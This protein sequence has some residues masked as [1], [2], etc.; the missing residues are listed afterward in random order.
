VGGGGHAEALLSRLTPTGVLFC[1]DADAD[2]I[3]AARVRL[4]PFGDRAQFV[5]ANFRTL[6]AELAARSVLSISGIILDLGLS[7]YQVDEP[8]RG[9]SYR[10]NAPL[11]MRFDQRSGTTAA[12]II[13]SY[14][15]QSLAAVLYEFGEERASRRIARA[16]VARRPIR[17]SGELA[18]AV[19]SVCGGRFATKTL[20]R[21]FQ[22]LRIAVNRELDALQAVLED[23][24]V[25]VAT[26]GRIVVISYHSL[27]DRMVKA[28]FRAAAGAAAEQEL[29]PYPPAG[30]I[31]LL[32]VLTRKPLR[33]G[34]EECRRN[35]RARSARLRIAE[36]L[37]A[38]SG[39]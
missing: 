36:R 12:E 18:Q 27:E 34:A 37:S 23:A 32:R 16:I 31:P 4:R 30:R 3:A 9:F 2:A 39:P 13:N 6:R 19:G 17:T 21:V 24:T 25:L 38:E 22:A 10:S 1:F 5:H 35:P 33:P 8:S 15:A 28:H 29:T 11:D 26:G 14:D 7:S 20:A